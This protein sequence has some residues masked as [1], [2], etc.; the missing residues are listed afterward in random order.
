MSEKKMHGAM[1][2]R[3]DNPETL[4]TSQRHWAQVRERKQIK[5]KAQQRKLKI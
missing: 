3:M 1:E 4:S 5:Q 2:S